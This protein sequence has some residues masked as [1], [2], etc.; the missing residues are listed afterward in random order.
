MRVFMLEHDT[1]TRLG[2]EVYRDPVV[3]ALF[4]GT[5]AP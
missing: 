1:V 2:A 5:L 3:S 4:D